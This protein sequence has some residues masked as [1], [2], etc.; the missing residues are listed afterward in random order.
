MVKD[1]DGYNDYIRLTMER[2]ADFLAEG[3]SDG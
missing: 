1:I 3:G 2:G